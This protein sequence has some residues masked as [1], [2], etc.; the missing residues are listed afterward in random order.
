MKKV[1]IIA[2]ALMFSM[3]SVD[4]SAQSF[5]KKLG[6]AV[7]SEIQKAKN[8]RSKKQSVAESEKE[9]EESPSFEEASR[10]SNKS[11]KKKPN[12]NIE[13]EGSLDEKVMI[14]DGSLTGSVA[15]HQWV[16]MGLPSGTRWATCN[17]GATKSSQA[18]NYY[19]WGETTTKSTFSESNYKIKNVNDMGDIAGKVSNDAAAKAWGSG[20]RMPTAQEFC[21]LLVFCDGEYTKVDG[22]W[23]Y[24]FTNPKNGQSIFI[25][26]TGYKYESTFSNPN[27]CGS[28]WTST[29]YR[30]GAN[31]NPCTVQ[32]GAALCE[33]GNGMAS[34]GLAIRPVLSKEK[35]VKSPVSGTTNGHDWVDLGL[36]SGNKWATCNL[37]AA[38][39]DDFGSYYAWGEIASSL[40]NPTKRNNMEDNKNA[41]DISG[42]SRYD[43]ASHAWGNG[44]RMPSRSDFEELMENCVW[45]WVSAAGRKGFKVTSKE[46]DNWIFIPTTGLAVRPSTFASTKVFEV[47]ENFNEIGVYWTSTPEYIDW[48]Y[49]KESY[50]FHFSTRDG[51]AGFPGFTS[52]HRFSCYNIRPVMSE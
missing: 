7:N 27:T 36:P 40:E 21:E 44:W 50:N 33:M 28:Y 45:E 22:R 5:L 1:L 43:A 3:G 11:E 26:A 6:K 15:G 32:Y 49:T 51:V 25:P 12:D 30:Q 13:I 46:N 10:E 2:F 9:S 17:L 52:G 34:S 42:N 41:T 37:G 47:A 16:D 20:W 48:G 39:P 29:P 35:H 19:A 38:Y 23:G 18:G 8:K 14:A 31:N 4:V 24:K